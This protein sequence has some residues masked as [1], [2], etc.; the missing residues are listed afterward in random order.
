MQHRTPH[1]APGVEEVAMSDQALMQLVRWMPLLLIIG[2]LVGAAIVYL[3]PKG[4][5]WMAF[6][7]G[8][9]MAAAMLLTR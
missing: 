1:R 2:P 9:L 8:A 3:L 5:L 4:P 7:G 6:Y